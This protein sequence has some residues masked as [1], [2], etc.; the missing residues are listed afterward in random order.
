MLNALHTD[1]SLMVRMKST[2]SCKHN[3]LP[4]DLEMNRFV[5]QNKNKRISIQG[6]ELF[7]YENLSLIHI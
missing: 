7:K 5:E 2:S 1:L 3:L 6:K 4:G